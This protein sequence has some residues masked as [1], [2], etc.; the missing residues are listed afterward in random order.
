MLISEEN[1]FIFFMKSSWRN[2]DISFLSVEKMAS[3]IM[4][5]RAPK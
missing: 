4:H 2:Q 3:Y 5:P 1:L